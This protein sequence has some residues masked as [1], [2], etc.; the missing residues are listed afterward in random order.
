MGYK[1]GPRLRESRLRAPSGRGGR[2]HAT[3]GPPFSRSLYICSRLCLENSW[4]MMWK[5]DNTTLL[6]PT[7]ANSSTKITPQLCCAN[8]YK[9]TAVA[10]AALFVL[11]VTLNVFFGDLSTFSL[12]K[13]FQFERRAPKVSAISILEGTRRTISRVLLLA[14]PR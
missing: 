13:Q 12:Q 2:V 1:V 4:N 3:Y 7:P 8:Y 9:A 14:Y 5:R 6:D 11:G 10:V